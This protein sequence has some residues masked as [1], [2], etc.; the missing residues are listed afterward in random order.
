MS[1]GRSISAFLSS[2]VGVLILLALVRVL[3]QVFTNGQYG[4]YQA[5]LVTMD[6]ATRHLAWGYAA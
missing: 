2:D 5:E 4:F 1:K 6:I 3:P